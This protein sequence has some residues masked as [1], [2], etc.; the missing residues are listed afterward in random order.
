MKSPPCKAAA[1]ETTAINAG[2]AIKKTVLFYS[3]KTALISG[4]TTQAAEPSAAAGTVN[5]I[6]LHLTPATNGNGYQG[7][8]VNNVAPYN[9]P[10]N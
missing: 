9:M 1:S 8:T 5:E 2:S 6:F 7:N 3:K 4:P 10:A